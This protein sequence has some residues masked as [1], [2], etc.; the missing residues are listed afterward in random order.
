MLPVFYSVGGAILYTVLPL[1]TLLLGQILSVFYTVGGA[2]LYCATPPYT[3]VGVDARFL[4]GWLRDPLL[5]YPPLHYNW[6][7]FC[8]FF[9]V[10]LAALSSTVL[11]PP[12]TLLLGNPL[13]GYPLK[14]RLG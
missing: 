11:P 1:P 6:G 14:L 7:R 12:L 3:T 8:P 10:R 13:L 5:L 9:F 4:H 2:I